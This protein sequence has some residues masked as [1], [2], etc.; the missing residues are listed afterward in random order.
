MRRPPRAEGGRSRRRAHEP[1]R[2]GRHDCFN[3]ADVDAVVRVEV[4]AGERFA[5]MI[6]ALLG[7]HVMMRE[8]E[9]SA[10]PGRAGARSGATDGR[11]PVQG[12]RR[13]GARAPAEAA[14]IHPA[15]RTRA[16]RATTGSPRPERT[17]GCPAVSLN[18]YEKIWP[19]SGVVLMRERAQ[20]DCSSYIHRLAA[21]AHASSSVR[22]LPLA[23]GTAVPR[24]IGVG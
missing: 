10:Q 4:T 14:V 16:D 20:A 23:H 17:A 19:V 12:E 22:R 6:D 5:H 21:P 13:A 18:A 24:A 7:L 1:Q 3:A 11:R 2:C 9:G 15:L 8:R